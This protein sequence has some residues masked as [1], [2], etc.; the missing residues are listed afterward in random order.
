MSFKESVGRKPPDE[1]TVIV[2]FKLSKILIPDIMNNEK[3][4][5]DNDK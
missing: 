4:S 2:K 1:I 5:T 3:I